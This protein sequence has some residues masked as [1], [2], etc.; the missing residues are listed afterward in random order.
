MATFIEGGRI[1]FG[2]QEFVVP[3]ATLRTCL[4]MEDVQKVLSAGEMSTL[5]GISGLLLLLLKPAQPE[6]TLEQ[7]LDLPIEGPDELVEA[8][9]TAQLLAGFKRVKSGEAARP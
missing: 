4:A 8:F 3:K 7:L 6:L 2:G 9:Q 5:V 1:T